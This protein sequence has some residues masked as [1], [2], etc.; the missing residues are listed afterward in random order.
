MLKVLE[1]LSDGQKQIASDTGEIKTRLEAIEKKQILDEIEIEKLK[2][3]HELPKT[4][5]DRLKKVEAIMPIVEDLKVYASPKWTG[6]R[7]AILAI[8][9]TLG[10]LVLSEQFPE[11]IHKIF[12]R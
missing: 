3:L 8:I 1:S 9:V 4:F 7:W 2:V 5:D 11:F 10:V 12:G 6:I